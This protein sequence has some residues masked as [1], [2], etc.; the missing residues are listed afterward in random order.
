MCSSDLFVGV[1]GVGLLVTV[2]AGLTWLALKYTLG[3]RVAEEEELEG[4]DIGEHGMEAYPGFVQARH[5][6]SAEV[7]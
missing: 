7:V 2:T 6:A 3:I 4:L 5:T 1:A